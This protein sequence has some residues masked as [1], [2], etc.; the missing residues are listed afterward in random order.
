MKF[1]SDSIFP[2][3]N[4]TDE[5][6][7]LCFGGDLE[8]LTLIDAYSHGI[9]PWPQKN[10]PLIWFSIP[11]RGILDFSKLHI[12][13]RLRRYLSSWKGEFRMDTCFG[14]VIKACAQ[15]IRSDQNDTWILPEMIE[16]YINLYR[17]GYAH[18]VEAWESGEL[19]G[20]IYGVFI[21]NV[22]SAESMFYRRSNSSKLCLLFLVEHLKKIGLDWMDI[23]VLTSIT[24][25]LGGEYIPR[26]EFLERLEKQRSKEKIFFL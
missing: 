5:N 20:G 25:Q 26:E 24:E 18:C 14:D 7:I 4:L 12:S 2:D 16:A 19:V 22:F 3:P 8:V 15:Q 6:G 23:Q 11:R 10:L 21:A 17:A 1:I 9:F 13:K